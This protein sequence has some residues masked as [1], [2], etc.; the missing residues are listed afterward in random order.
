MLAFMKRYG[1]MIV[2]VCVMLTAGV[3]AAIGAS[4][5][6]M[7]TAVS[8]TVD[9]LGRICFLGWLPVG[10]VGVALFVLGLVRVSQSRR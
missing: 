9:R 1:L 6:V 2:G 7:P 3:M 5:F 8:P 10:L 4:I